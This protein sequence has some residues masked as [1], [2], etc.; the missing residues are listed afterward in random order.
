MINGQYHTER[1]Y[2][3]KK[4]VIDI[5]EICGHYEIAVLAKGGK[6]LEMETVRTIQEA[7][8]IYAEYLKK[9]PKS[10]AP[11]TGKYK[12]LSDAIRE[13]IKAGQAAE[14][15]NPEDGGTCN[16]DAT[17]IY[18]PRRQESKVLQAAKE[19]GT[20]AW[21]YKPGLY[22]INPVSNGQ[23]NTRSRNA[24]VMTAK[25]SVLG[26]QTTDYCEMD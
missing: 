7:R 17:L 6:E 24:E 12:R 5:A 10:P 25:L 9:Y 8:D 1:I 4:I 15:E 3:G 26:Y 21:K 19:A 23:A 14:A 13:A 18:L 16:F 2:K 22:V 20:T 11:L